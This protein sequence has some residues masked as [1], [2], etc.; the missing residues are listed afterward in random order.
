M[1]AYCLKALRDSSLMRQKLGVEYV[2]E[3]ILL[4]SV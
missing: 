1:S 3:S 4:L 2:V